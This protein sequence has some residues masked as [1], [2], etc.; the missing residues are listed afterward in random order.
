MSDEVKA[1]VSI[2]TN[3]VRDEGLDKKA[4]LKNVETTIDSY[5]SIQLTPEEK[6]K[7][8]VHLAHLKT[9]LQAMVPLKCGGP[10]C[11]EVFR[12]NCPLA[13]MN[14]APMGKQCFMEV[15]LFM[16][17]RE[18][19]INE[20]G[21]D[22]MSP[23]E[24][25]MANELAELDVLELRATMAMAEPDMAQMV[26]ENVVG[27]TKEGEPISMLGV[28]PLWEAKER[29]KAR[30]S[31]IIKLLVGDRQEKYKREAALKKTDGSDASTAMAKFLVNVNAVT[32]KVK[33]LADQSVIDVDSFDK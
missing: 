7:L 12:K 10:K 3:L 14:K 4:F 32:A 26:T 18:G 6:Q 33:D 25:G 13:Q 29:L 15:S 2:D 31:R 1:L 5:E 24:V 23:T 11:P 8:K 22:P 19:Y 16:V 30:R 21:V 17:W 27:V 28:N 9:G 20:Y